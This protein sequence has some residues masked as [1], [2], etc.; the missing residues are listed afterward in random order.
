MKHFIASSARKITA[1]FSSIVFLL[2][3]TST[4]FAAGLPKLEAPSKGDDG[5]IIEIIKNYAY[6]GLILFGLGLCAW[7]FMEV[8]SAAIETFSQVKNKKSSWGNFG[9][10]LIA[11]VI[12]IVIIIWLATQAVE[13]F[14]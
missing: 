10:M 13:I 11:G 5:G 3:T 8:A 6:D 1:F 12:L 9:A 2:Y 7:A 14:A 4:A